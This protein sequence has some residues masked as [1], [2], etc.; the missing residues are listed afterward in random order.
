MFLVVSHLTHTPL[1]PW[2][3]NGINEGVIA[4][5]SNDAA[6]S[7]MNVDSGGILT[8]R[9]AARFLPLSQNFNV[10]REWPRPE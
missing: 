9:P 1:P 2:S 4:D 3:L 6:P 10:D 8:A 7:K 5:R